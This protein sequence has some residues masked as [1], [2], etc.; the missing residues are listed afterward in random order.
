MN[1]WAVILIAAWPLGARGELEWLPQPTPVVFAGVPQAVPSIIRNRADIAVRQEIRGRVTQ[2]SSST[3]MPLPLVE[4]RKRIEVLPGQT[5]IE[6]VTVTLP[7]VNANT[8]FRIH[9][10]DEAGRWLG[11]SEVIG[12]PDNTLEQLKAAGAAQTIHLHDPEGVFEPLFAQGKVRHET[13]RSRADVDAVKHG[14]VLIAPFEMGARDREDF[15]TKL[16]KKAGEAGVAVVW[17]RAPDHRLTIPAPVWLASHGAG[18]LVVAPGLLVADLKDSAAAQVNLIQ[19]VELAL[20][21]A[22][23]GLILEG[24]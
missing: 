8:R 12:C 10:M 20:K 1:R 2:L 15:A 17:F 9:W 24:Q 14:L 3:Q 21:P 22:R 18:T 19:C 13:L 7:S 16:A 5:V 11:A 23:F 4:P 6:T